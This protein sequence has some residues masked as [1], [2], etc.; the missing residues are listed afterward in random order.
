MPPPS[1]VRIAELVSLAQSKRIE[2][3]DTLFE[4][5]AELFLAEDV[6]LNDRERALMRSIL[7]RLL[8]DVE[9]H[10]RRALAVRIAELPDAPVE[11]V[12]LLANDRIDI[13]QPILL[14]SRALRDP[15]LIEVIRQRG[16]EHALAVTMRAG[17]TP[18]VTDA[19]VATGNE[20]VIERLLENTDAELSRRATEYLVA[21]SRRVGRFREPLVRRQDLPPDLAARMYWWVS[22]ALRQC[23]LETIAASAFDIDALVADTTESLTAQGARADPTIDQTAL[24]LVNRLVERQELSPVLL[25]R[26][27]RS[28]RVN[29]FIAGLSRQA[30]IGTATV[31]HILFDEGGESLAL[32]CKANLWARA[33]FGEAYLLSRRFGEQSVVPPAVLEASLRFYDDL[34][35]DTARSMLRFWQ[36]DERYLAVIDGIADATGGAPER[37]KPDAAARP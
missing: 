32:L 35:V 6:K 17:L 34:A 3:R 13:A 20:D 29:A 2:Q 9:M 21:E 10:V 25:I 14:K 27:L 26:F 7:H 22:A 24:D 33:H 28:G 1:K 30:R 19:L 37:P 5:I 11:L 12:N 36:R 18:D 8:H 16:K 15:D 23:L 4:N 31:R